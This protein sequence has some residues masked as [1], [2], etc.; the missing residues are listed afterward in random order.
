MADKLDL[1]N[2]ILFVGEKLAEDDFASAIDTLTPLIDLKV[3]AALQIMGTMYQCVIGVEVNGIKAEK[4]LKEAADAGDALVAHNLGT[5]YATGAPDLLQNIDLSKLYHDR[6][7]ELDKRL[8]RNG[9]N[10]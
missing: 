9:A 1:F 10:D 4:F 7:H 8:G 5:L 3:P 6:A 2:Q